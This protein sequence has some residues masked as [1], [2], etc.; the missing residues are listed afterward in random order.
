MYRTKKKRILWFF[1]I[2][3]SLCLCS[4]KKQ[5]TEILVED[6]VQKITEEEELKEGPVQKKEK[7]PTKP[8][9]IWVDVSGAV[10]N[11]GVYE[12]PEN[13]RVFEA[14]ETAGGFLEQ[15]D[16]QWLNQALVL[17]DGEKIQVY[18]KE[19]TEELKAKGIGG[20]AVVESGFGTERW[21]K[22]TGL[23]QRGDRR[24]KGEGYFCPECR[25]STGTP[26]FKWREIQWKG[27]PKYG[28]SR[29]T[30]GNSG[31]RRSTCQSYFGVSPADW[32]IS[33][34]I[35]WREIQWKG[36]PKYGYSRPTSGNSGN[37]RST[38]QSYFG[39]SPADWRIS[40]HR[41]N[42]AGTWY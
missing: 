10:A 31:N 25:G 18:T 38:C 3:C 1:L 16:T 40:E 26:I 34:H 5:G 32:R 6:T 35:K 15:A 2:V 19:E 7:T 28:Y 22:D 21:R 12:L 8:A 41:R 36:K 29:P 27:K 9:S 23:Y 17:K 39:V 13:A 20:Y 4:C 33:E 30:S 37:R 14:I 42:T 11:P 24:A